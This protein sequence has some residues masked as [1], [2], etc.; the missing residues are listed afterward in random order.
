MIVYRGWLYL[1][2]NRVLRLLNC[3]EM[4]SKNINT[5]HRELFTFTYYLLRVVLSSLN[6]S[7]SNVHI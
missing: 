1:V 5:R 7:F 3:S 6:E 2:K 4:N